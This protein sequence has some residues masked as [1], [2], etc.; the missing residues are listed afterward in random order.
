M[1][2][3]THVPLEHDMY[4]II[5]ST[6]CQHN[7]RNFLLKLNILK[8]IGWRISSEIQHPSWHDFWIAKIMSQFIEISECIF[9]LCIRKPMTF[10]YFTVS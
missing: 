4:I 7:L 6:I 1:D 8:I 2:Y 3:I 5:R 9:L 10:T